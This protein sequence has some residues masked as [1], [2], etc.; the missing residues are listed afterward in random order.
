MAIERVI[1]QNGFDSHTNEDR[2][3]ITLIN[4][5]QS[6]SPEQIRVVLL[7]KSSE[8]GNHWREYPE[9]YGAIGK[10]V[11]SL[12]DIDTKATK[13]HTLMTGDRIFIPPRVALKIKA[14]KGTVIVICSPKCKRDEGTHKYKL[15]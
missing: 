14:E 11:F 6:F 12:E 1:Y 3:I 2:T 13:E 15:A 8:L 9:V 7:K 10:V 4:E 5:K